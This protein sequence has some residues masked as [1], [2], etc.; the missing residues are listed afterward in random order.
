MRK[1]T[2][3]AILLLMVL[4][5]VASVLP[6]AVLATGET[7]SPFKGWSLTL[8]DNIGVNFYLTKDVAYT[9]NVTVDGVE[10][11]YVQTETDDNYILN[12]KVAAAQM[13]DTIALT[14]KNGEAVVHT[15]EY[16]VR[17]YAETILQGN[18]DDSVKQMVLQMLNYGAAAQKYF[19][20][21]TTSPANAGYELDSQA[22]V[23]NEVPAIAPEGSAEG[24]T[25]YG[26]SLVFESK[27]AVRFYFTGDVS[28]HEFKVND[29][30][31]SPVSKNSMHYVEVGNIN[32]QD[33]DKQ[34]TVTVD[35][36]LSVS[37][38]PMN[39]IVRQYNSSNSSDELK[40]LVQVMY[41]YYLQAKDYQ[42]AVDATEIELPVSYDMN[43]AGNDLVVSNIA[44]NGN[45]VGV[46]VQGTEISLGNA[47]MKNNTLT[48]PAASFQQDTMPSGKLTLEVVTDTKTI[49]VSGEFIWVIP[50]WAGMAA[51]EKHMVSDGTAYTGSLALGADIDA[52]GKTISNFLWKSITNFNGSF[53]GRNYTIS[54]VK[55]PK[56]NYGLFRDL[57]ADGVIK[58]VKL[59]GVTVT[60]NAG[61]LV[62]GTVS[63]T[64]ENIYVEGSVTAD[65]MKADSNLANFGAGLLCGKIQSGA[66][67][68][69]VIVE[70]TDITDGLYLATAF[71]KLN[72]AGATEDSVFTNC[73]AVNAD[74]CT[75]AKHSTWEKV[76]F[77]QGGSNANFAD[78]ASLWADEAAAL[79]AKQIGLSKPSVS[80]ALDNSFDMNVAGNDLVLNVAAEP[81]S[82]TVQGTDI[83]LTGTW[84]DGKLTI[85]AKSFQ[86]DNM[87]SG[88]LTLAV[89]TAAC[90]Y[91]FTGDFIWVINNASDLLKMRNHMTTSDESVYG[92]MLALGANI[93]LDDVTIKNNG[94][95]GKTF[96]GS[97]DGRMFTLSNMKAD[98][99]NIGLFGHVSGT[100]KNL[101]F[102]N[103][104][105]SSYTAAIAGG[106][107]SGTI[108]NVYVQ[109]TI[110][111]DGM[112]ATSNL[113]N[114]GAGLLVGRIQ[115][116]AK[117]N[118]VIVELTDIA[119]NLYLATA[120]GKMHQSGATEASVFTNCYAINAD[121]C[122]FAM[123]GTWEK[124]SFT[125]G[126]S[127][128]NFADLDALWANEAAAAL[129]ESFGL[130]KAGKKE[131]AIELENSY[132]MNVAGSNF[133][134][135][136]ANLTGALVS[137]TIQGSE[138]V[139]ADATLE[140]G[141]LT[142][143][144]ASFQ[145]DTMPSGVLTL[146]VVTDKVDCTISGE[147]VW[148][149]HNS[150]ELLAMK[151]HLVSEDA[152]NYTGSLAL[153]ADIDAIS[154]NANNGLFAKTEVFAGT[155][156]GRM[157]SI[158]SITVKAGGVGLF[159]YVSG[160]ICNLKVLDSAVSS[161]TAPL[162]GGILTGTIE[163][164]YI[165]GSITAD[166]IGANSNRNNFGCGLLAARYK[167]GAKVTNVIVDVES[168]ADGLYLATAFGKFGDTVNPENVFT[169][170]Y[171]IG[172]G[173][174]AY[175]TYAS[176]YT[177]TV[178]LALPGES[179]GNYASLYA[180]WNENATAKALAQD[181]FKLA[182]P[183]KPV[184]A[185]TMAK[186]YDMNV[187]GN[188]LVVADGRL[189]GTVSSVAVQGTEIVLENATISNGVLTIPA[190][191]FQFDTMP[192][193]NLTLVI[194]S[195]MMECTV[196]GEFV[197]VIPNWAGM[198]AME[199][200]M[201]SDGTAY[202]GSL[203]LGADIDV[204]GK[205][206]TNFLWKTITKFN[207]TFDG[208]NHTISGVKT[209]KGNYGLFRDLGADG[210][211]KNL[212]LTNATVTTYAGALVGGE[213]L[214]TLE[215][216]Y[217][218]GAITG[219]GMSASSNLANFGSGLLAGRIQ[220][221]AKI[222]NCIVNVTS[223]ASG[224]RLGSAFGKLNKSGA[225]EANVFTNCYAVNA[226]GCTFVKYSTWEKLSF[227]TGSTNANFADMT[228]LWADENAAALATALGLTQ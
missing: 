10:A 103:V 153:G 192:S 21:K 137:V 149:I 88:T 197:W 98:T 150:A 194:V 210:V 82:I 20:Y 132:D 220:A 221:G 166:G 207:G 140:N 60:T 119:D 111:A 7:E 180:M 154:F 99:G 89:K 11:N 72:Q 124:V 39:Y 52:T 174:Q 203:A 188:D 65:G 38:S 121:N 25:L 225:T 151:N 216:I 14:V 58:N 204:S 46:S 33:L 41:G 198:A 146:V 191:S 97:F 135:E 69:N 165:K 183:E 1:L 187:A 80:I 185:I 102:T 107:F 110:T 117:I 178:K 170:C 148:V 131:L 70:L 182:E 74:N 193:G 173:N 118:N 133:V 129:A 100:V 125:E 227:T 73:Y 205:T 222:N 61:G 81:E 87:P 18:Y 159:T 195:D 31:L 57:G 93:D 108:E 147:F 5:L 49:A 17:Q 217:V 136:N 35:G 54:G 42:K 126:G 27:T 6:A 66:K 86:Q 120:F 128:A 96:A 71:G 130:E 190:A 138:L 168:I 141:V 83:T 75:F 145:L 115:T 37:Y 215:N 175:M 167:Y 226:D 51:M 94:M 3:R 105:V 177:K 44:L 43:I 219:D 228:A 134:V 104:T 16:S 201:V 218:E 169:N 139:L 22:E 164:V 28:G 186:S 199:K 200:H 29:T 196:S 156:D 179:N 40:A 212:K 59:T 157:H 213:L 19:G 181:T 224:L 8:G 78:I 106:L 92:G 109:G 223:I 85:P 76:S 67:I 152:G 172:A 64:L 56:G 171:A 24:V 214:G 127:N 189:A 163:N 15:G 144:A 155:F 114:F 2:N 113:T 161:Y 101:K 79:V 184:V 32:P 211:I 36:T 162:V 62:G 53:D 116:G 90:D 13:T 77:T 26:M 176:D 202:T 209:P 112:K 160:K 84:A 122:T 50:N 91:A 34:I 47:T 123:H 48:I 30:V 4:A 9:A 206:I 143:P 23:S 55:T 63:G 208:R 95:S 68:N 45:L 142:I 158:S 12:V